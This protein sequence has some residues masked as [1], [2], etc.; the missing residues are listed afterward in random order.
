M[1]CIIQTTGW[2]KCSLW[3]NVSHDFV[4]AGPNGAYNV[5]STIQPPALTRIQCHTIAPEARLHS[6]VPQSFQKVSLIGQVLFGYF[7]EISKKWLSFLKRRTFTKPFKNS[8][9]AARG[10]PVPTRTKHLITAYS[11]WVEFIE[12]P[13]LICMMF[14]CTFA[15]LSYMHT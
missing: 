5:W 7:L 2:K 8:R 1:A 9:L 12:V 3:F 15:P 4:L 10:S 13:F 6:L 14:F 11:L